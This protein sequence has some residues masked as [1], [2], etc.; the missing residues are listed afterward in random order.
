[1]VFV[2]CAST[3]GMESDGNETHWQQQTNLPGC[4]DIP[5][6]QAVCIVFFDLHSLSMH[7]KL[8]LSFQTILE[9]VV[10]REKKA[11]ETKPGL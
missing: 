7:C 8:E 1:M 11:K 2:P 6:P 3:A 4:S 5:V 9:V 10:E